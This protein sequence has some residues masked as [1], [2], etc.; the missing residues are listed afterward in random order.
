MLNKINK[1]GSLFQIILFALLLNSSFCLASDLTEISHE[2]SVQL[3]TWLDAHNSYRLAAT[4]DCECESFI[5]TIR[6][7]DGNAWK[8]QPNY[9]PYYSVGDLSGNGGKDF[10]VMLRKKSGIEQ[11]IVLIFIAKKNQKTVN[12]I[13]YKVKDSTVVGLGL[14]KSLETPSRLLIGPFGSEGEVIPIY[15][16]L[17]K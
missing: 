7:G 15:S 6:Q 14:F 5:Q 3:Q 12:P 17:E 2:H 16:K 11:P 9:Q 4:K 1:I 8:P 10:A 13:L